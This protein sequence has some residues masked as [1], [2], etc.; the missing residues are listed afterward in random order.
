V[1]LA[2]RGA[3]KIVCQGPAWRE[4]ACELLGFKVDDA[5]IIP[6]W[7]ATAELLKLGRERC[8]RTREAVQL[9]FV[10]SLNR[11][12]G[13]RELLEAFQAVARQR[14]STLTFV[15]EGDMS[16]EARG[17]IK[18]NRLD[19]VVTFR[20]WLD[21]AALRHE[22][23]AADV[24]VLPS[25]VEGLPNAMIEALAAGLAVVVTAVGSIPDVIANGQN[26]LVVP[27]RD[28]R[29]LSAALIRVIDDVE[30][31]GR[32][33]SSGHELAGKLF[34]AESAADALIAQI[35]SVAGRNTRLAR[36]SA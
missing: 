26:G 32:L 16:S 17:F 21:A 10:G 28:A 6:S 25:W 9:L 22:Y 34:G 1:R 19:D 20:G 3:R 4:F 12:K 36:S 35:D 29:A 13:I 33:A 30:L 23:A 15:G 31:R 2:F 8:T 11:D 7:T 14:P 27:P 18:S 24:F 5:P